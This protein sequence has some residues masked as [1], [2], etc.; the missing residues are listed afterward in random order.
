MNYEPSFQTFEKNEGSD[1]AGI[2][3]L[4]KKHDPRATV[5]L[6]MASELSYKLDNS[7]RLRFPA[8]LQ[9][10][11][12]NAKKLGLQGYGISLTGME[13]V[14]FRWPCEICFSEIKLK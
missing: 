2:E 1:I 4:V 12:E 5:S 6:N 10:I 14:F 7:F 8:L 13:E 9:E 11:E 3:A